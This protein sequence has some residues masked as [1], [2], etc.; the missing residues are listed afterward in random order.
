M[1]RSSH[2]ARAALVPTGT[3]TCYLRA[4]LRC[5]D[6]S[7]D[8]TRLCLRVL[9]CVLDV[10]RV[11]TILRSF[12]RPYCEAFITTKT[13]TLL[14]GMMTFFVT[15]VAQKLNIRLVKKKCDVTFRL[16]RVAKMMQSQTLRLLTRRGSALLTTIATFFDNASAEARPTVVKVPTNTGVHRLGF[17]L[18]NARTLVRTIHMFPLVT[19]GASTFEL[20]SACLASNNFHTSTSELAPAFSVSEHRAAFGDRLLAC[21]ALHSFRL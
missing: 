16:V 8:I 21:L 2:C 6:H 5:E 19:A 12:A 18:R 3:G 7:A 20:F 15:A 10:A 14:V 17:S 11:R 1:D 4:V 9:S 13:L